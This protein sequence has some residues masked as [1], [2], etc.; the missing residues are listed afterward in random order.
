[1]SLTDS[2][3]L[4]FLFQLD[5]WE[6]IIFLF[7]LMIISMS[8][9]SSIA[10]KRLIKNN[11]VENPANTTVYSAVFGLLAFLL[12]FT[13]SMSGA[14]FDSRRQASVAEGNAIGTAILRADL[15]PDSERIPLRSDLK[16]YLKGRIASIT[17]RSNSVQVGKAD[18][19][20]A[21]YSGRLWKRATDFSKSSS[22]VVI[23]NQMIPALN[24]MFDSAST[25]TYSERMRV[26]QSIVAM[27][28][29]LSIISSF[30][31]GYL[32]VGKGRF[33]W[34]L[35]TGFCLL[36]SLVIF[37]TLDLDRPRRGLI[38]MDT[39]HDAIISLMKQ[40]DK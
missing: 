15:Y 25:N 2:Y 6:L 11:N 12:A 9:G 36:T 38:Q 19:V 22:N 32:S 21:V 40:F 20:A 29:I 26:P 10:R 24:A 30:F 8:L 3:Q 14:R 4:P 31:V 13:F 1:M 23:S 17:G 28:F 27:L 35:G 39:S 37:I 5:I 7:S 33:D 34:L 18:S 16:E